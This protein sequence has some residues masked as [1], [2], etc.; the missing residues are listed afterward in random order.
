MFFWGAVSAFE[1]YVAELQEFLRTHITSSD[2]PATRKPTGSKA[3]S[4]HTE[5]QRYLYVVCIE[6]AAVDART[7]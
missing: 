2:M 3:S 4:P 1:R 7:P 6:S 5:A